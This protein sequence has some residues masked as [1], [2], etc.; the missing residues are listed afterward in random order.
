[1]FNAGCYWQLARRGELSEQLLRNGHPSPERSG[2]PFCT[3]SQIIAYFDA[4]GNQLAIVHQ[5]LRP[6]GTIGASGKPD[7]KRLR[8]GD[9]IYYV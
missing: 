4:E 2:E 6:D 8:Q 7:P 5:Y 9:T 1:M 3:R